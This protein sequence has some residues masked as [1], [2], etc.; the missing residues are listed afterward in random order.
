MLVIRNLSNGHVLAERAEMAQG[1]VRRMVGLLTRSALHEGEAMV[2]PRCRSIQTCFMRFPID[3]VF[4]K[5][6]GNLEWKSTTPSSGLQT[7]PSSYYVVVKV[8]QALKPFRIAWAMEADTVIELP[9]YTISRTL[10]QV[11]ARLAI[12]NQTS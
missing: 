3:V 1:L 4:L 6:T 11:G 10:T 7:P 12:A 8:V 5:T 2:F 9:V